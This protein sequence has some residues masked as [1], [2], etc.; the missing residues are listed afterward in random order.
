MA[1]LGGFM[2]VF[3]WLYGVLGGFGVLVWRF[4]W[5]YGVFRA[6]IYGCF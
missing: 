1:F 4:R 3:R 6:E 2:A 5:L